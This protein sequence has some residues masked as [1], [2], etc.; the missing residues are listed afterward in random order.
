[1]GQVSYFL[2]PKKLE[3]GARASFLFD[4]LTDVGVNLNMG[5]NNITRLG[6]PALKGGDVNGDSDNEQEY[7]LGANYYFNGFNAKLQA[8][9]TMFVD[10]IVGPDDLVNHIGLL[11]LQVNF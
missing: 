1:M 7:T 10:G 6:N 11:Q 8:Q 2:I 9:Y 5:G 3:L 4:D